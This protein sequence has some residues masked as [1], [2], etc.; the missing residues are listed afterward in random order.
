MYKLSYAYTVKFMKE[1]SSNVKTYHQSH[2]RLAT[3]IFHPAHRMWWS[4]Q[5]W[6]VQR[7]RLLQQ[8][9]VSRLSRQRLFQLWP[10]NTLRENKNGHY[11]TYHNCLCVAFRKGRNEKRNY[12]YYRSH[13][14]ARNYRH[15]RKCMWAFRLN[16]KLI[17]LSFVLLW[18]S[19]F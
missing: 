5:M 1:G 16:G 9:D 8:K 12:L 19:P 7:F 18:K 17:L 4:P 6:D 3:A 10:L 2:S 15:N 14:H 13:C 11:I